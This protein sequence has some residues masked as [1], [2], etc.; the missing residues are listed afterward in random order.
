MHRHVI[1]RGE[2]SG[3]FPF[4]PLFPLFPVS[5]KFDYEQH[6]QQLCAGFTAILHPTIFDPSQRLHG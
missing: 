1:E 5:S 3:D 4:V 6:T 2:K